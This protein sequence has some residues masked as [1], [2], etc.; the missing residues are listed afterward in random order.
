MYNS[1][2]TNKDPIAWLDNPHPL[3]PLSPS[4]YLWTS[5]SS[6]KHMKLLA[7]ING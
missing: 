4:R 7:L 1:S 6:P 5:A 3:F 2:P